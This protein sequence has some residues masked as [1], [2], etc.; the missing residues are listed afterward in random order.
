MTNDIILGITTYYN[1]IKNE[2]KKMIF[3]LIIQF[4]ILSLKYKY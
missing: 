3:F 1:K 4:G 2:M